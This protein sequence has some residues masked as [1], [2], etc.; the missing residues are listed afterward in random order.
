METMEIYNNTSNGKDLAEK[1]R[2]PTINVDNIK[3]IGTD[4]YDIPDRDLPPVLDPY[5]A[6]ERSK[7]QIPSLSERIKNTVKTN[8]YDDMKHMSPLGYMASDQSY[9][10]RFN[11]T[12]PEIS[13][14]DSRYRLSSGTWIPKYESYIPGVDNDT[15]LSRSQGRTEKWMRGLGKFV[16]K[17]ALY[18]L[19][20]VIQPFYGIYAG[21]SRGNF[22]AVFDN[23]FTRWLDDQDK[24]MDY[25]LAHYYNREER[26]MNFLQSMTTANFWSNDFLSGLAFTAGAMLSS[27]VYSGAGLMNLARTGAKA[28]VALARI[29]KAASDTKKAF[30]AYLRAARTG[31]RIGKGLD[32]LAFLGASTSWEASVEA[33]SMLMEAEENFRQSYRNAYGR[34]VPYEELMRFRADN[35][36]AANAVFAANVGILSLSN[37]AMFGDMFGMDLG[38]DKFIKRNIFGVGAERMDNGTLRAITPKKWQKV[39]GNTFNIIKRPVSEGLYEEGLQGVASKSAKD[40]VE[41]RYNPMAIR[42]NIGYME[43]IKNGFKETYGSS[44]GWKEIGIGMIIGSIMGGKTIGGIKEWSQDM[45]RNKGMVEAYNANAGALTTAAVRA[46]RGS[47]AL[48]TQLSGIDTSYESDGRIINKDFSGAVFNR[49]RYDSEMGMLDDTKENFRTVVESIPNSDIASDMNMTDEQVN[50][51]KADLVNE[52]NKKVD[53]FTMANRFADSLT[54]GISNRSFNTYISNMVYNGLEAKDN[55]DDIASQLNRLYKNDIGEALDVYSHLNPDSYKAISELMG[56]TSRMQALEKGILRLQRMAMGEERFERNKD[57]LAKKTDELAKLTEDKIV[58]E[59]KLATM[60]NSEADLS[61]LLFSDRSNRQISASDLMAA[62]NTITD[63]ENVVSIR[64]VDNHKEA[65]A[66]LSEYRHNLVAYKNINESLRRMR[67]KRFIRSQERGF[68]KILSNAWG[69]TYE[70]DDSKYDF[71]NT[72]NSDANALY[73][74]DQAIDKAFN[75]GLIGED[76]AFMFKTYNHMIARSMETDIQSGDNIV[77]NV[78]DDEDLLNPSD[79]RSTDIAIKIWNGNEDILSPRERQIYDNNKDRIDDIIKGFGDNPI[80]RLNKIRS[81]IDR[82]NINGDVSNNIKDA[83]DNIIDINI[84][85][86]DQDQVKEAIKTYNDLMNEADNGNE[87]DQDKLNE[88]IDIINNYSDGPLLQFV[89]WMRLYDNGSIAVKDYDKSIPMGDVLTESEPG[90]STGRTEVNAAQ[91]PVVL[92]AQKRE[93]GGVMY[94]EVGGMRLD[95]FMAGSGLKRS[96]ATDTDNGRVMDF[97]NGTDIFTVIESDNHSRWMISEDNAQAFENATGVILGRQTALSTSN[98]FMVYR[99][100]QDGSIVPYYTGDTFESNNESVNQEAAA[101]LRKGDMVRF[102]MDMSDPYTKEL[103][104]KYNSLNAVDPNSD[105]TKS[106]YRELVDNMVI[107]IVDSDGNFV[108]VLKAND[109]DSKGSNAD[110]RS[111]AFE[112]Y[113]DNVGSVAG[114][115]DIP[116][117]GTVTSVLPGRPNFSISDDNGTLM[118]SENDF[119][120]ETVGKVESVGYIENG[121]VTMRDDIKYNIFPF[122]T[123]IVRDKYGDYKNSRIPV[124]AIKTGNG[125]NYLYPV[126]LKNQDISSFS[127]M[128]ESMA[129]RITE[130]LGGGVS[131]D[132][133]MDLNNAIARSGLDNKTYMIPLAGD[134]DVIKGRLEAV[135]E[136]VSRMPMTADVR[137]WIGDSRTKEDILMNDVTINIDL[138]NDPFIAPKFRMS[139]RRDETFFEDTETPFVNPSSSQS[140]SASPTKAAEDKSLVSDGNVVSG[141]NEAENPC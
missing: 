78:P 75:D 30:G 105:E 66:L 56:L 5:S 31:R 13:L 35:A 131:I 36:N 134:V 87:V 111:M 136:A 28:G 21:V 132:D 22:N 126:R 102:K 114:E 98:W 59:R 3:A 47:M 55:L 33:R 130:G 80:A 92:M 86:L 34:E 57:K 83:I 108:S 39:A 74:N 119:T 18:G 140:G 10:G 100:G 88:T 89:E 84:N 53:N 7:S 141:E 117:V 85:G 19:G 139:I 112:L 42:Q 25:G 77:E 60:V 11:L 70:E 67:D 113:R 72:D 71:R 1:Y 29:G 94:Y 16:G 41:S 54:E 90:T 24:K 127:S 48:N 50:E 91:N 115:I 93:I 99:K 137:G 121:E 128:I 64:G 51:Y 122:C 109:P 107:K 125:R 40:W 49:L 12:G 52:F 120:N 124:V 20:G 61:S 14:E 69:K 26:D 116:F 27:A 6:S 129:D 37:I 123:A 9:K 135:K 45:S 44:Q 118:V 103:Y 76:E 4:P 63:L 82:L 96:D 79:D 17:A 133:I 65:M 8:Y 68:M 110:L 95:R 106:A 62:Y 2:Y 38:V 97:T 104:D 101:S 32:T 43:A 138:N 23:D 46:I 15:R 58:L 73:A 81:M